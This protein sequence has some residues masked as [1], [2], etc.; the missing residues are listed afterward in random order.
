MDTNKNGFLSQGDWTLWVDNIK[1]AM[2]ISPEDEA[3]LRDAHVQ[4]AVELGATEPGVQVPQ[5]EFLKNA[6]TFAASGDKIKTF[7][8]ELT[9]IWYRVLDMNHDGFISRDEFHKVAI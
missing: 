1:D 5:E 4:L 3:A 8:A 9:Q 7:L 6:A 2:K